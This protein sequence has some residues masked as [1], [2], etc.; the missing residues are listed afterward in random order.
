MRSVKRYSQPDDSK[1]G[2]EESLEGDEAGRL[3]TEMTLL[4]SLTV[5]AKKGLTPT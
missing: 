3:S 2:D 4:D 1:R 5:A